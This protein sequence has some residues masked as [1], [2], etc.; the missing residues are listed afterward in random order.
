MFGGCL[1]KSRER[2]HSF[3]DG[4]YGD[5]SDYWTERSMLLS[6][7]RLEWRRSSYC[8]SGACIE[9]ALTRANVYLRGAVPSEKLIISLER[10]VDFVASIKVDDL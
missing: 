5:D 3:I 10:W 2:F 6:V 4:G 9:V 1:Q 8:D 7:D